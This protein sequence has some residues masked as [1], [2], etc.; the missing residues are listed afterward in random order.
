MRTTRAILWLSCGMITILAGCSSS[1]Y[2]VNDP[3]GSKDYYTK[4]M[5]KTKTGGITFKD[6]R[7]GN[8]V[9]LQSSEVM[10]ISEEQFNA[11]KH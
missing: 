9:T 8:V 10:E 6:A 7:S 4:D 3:A 5:D 1:Y 2:L 11:A